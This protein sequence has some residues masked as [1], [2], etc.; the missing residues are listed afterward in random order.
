MDILATTVVNVMLSG[1]AKNADNSN[2][3]KLMEK[4]LTLFRGSDL[5]VHAYVFLLFRTKYISCTCVVALS[6][7]KTSTIS[8]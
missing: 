6:E 3:I 1:T 7:K 5:L 4:T 8:V 2:K